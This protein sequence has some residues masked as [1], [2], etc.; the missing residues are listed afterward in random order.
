VLAA[1]AGLASFEVLRKD[2]TGLYGLA[3]FSPDH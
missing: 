2:Q 3:V 1:Q